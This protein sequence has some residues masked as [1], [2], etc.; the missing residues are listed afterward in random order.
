MNATIIILLAVIII[1]LM[2]TMIRIS[3]YVLNKSKVVSIEDLVN[4][5]IIEAIDRTSMASVAK[6]SDKVKEVLKVWFTSPEVF[7]FKSDDNITLY[8][9]S[10]D[11][12]IWAANEMQHREFQGRPEINKHLTMYDKLVLD[13]IVKAC[14]ARDKFLKENMNKLV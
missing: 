14:K 7:H 4:S 6:L 9:S 3:K 12:E 1:L 2:A 13:A 5:I 11:I 8:I 10:L